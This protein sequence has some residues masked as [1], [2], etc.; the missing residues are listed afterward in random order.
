MK[1]IIEIFCKFIDL[2]IYFVILC[3]FMTWIPNLNWDFPAI[4]LMFWLAGFGILA[5]IPILSSFVPLI[6]I[7]LLI[8]FRKFLYKMIGEEDKFFGYETNTKKDEDLNDEDVN[9]DNEDNS[10]NDTNG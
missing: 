3:C 7:L 1:K 8:A 6:L 10:G 2:Y 5:N 9:D 4:Q